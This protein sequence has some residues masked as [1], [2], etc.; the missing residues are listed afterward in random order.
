MGYQWVFLY[1]VWNSFFNSIFV[2]L[3]LQIFDQILEHKTLIWAS[4]LLSTAQ[5]C[6]LSTSLNFIFDVLRWQDC[7][8]DNKRDAHIIVFTDSRSP[9]I[10]QKETKYSKKK[11]RDR[12]REFYQ[13]FNFQVTKKTLGSSTGPNMKSKT[14]F[15]IQFLP[16]K[17]ALTHYSKRSLVQF[18]IFNTLYNSPVNCLKGGIF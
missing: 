12:K 11:K 17:D 10:F 7:A 5:S 16:P 14:Q 13:I 6:H 2:C 9:S 18:F 8:V 4:L 15:L 3:N 1:E